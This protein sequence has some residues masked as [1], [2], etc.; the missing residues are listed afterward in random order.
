MCQ[1]WFYHQNCHQRHENSMVPLALLWGGN[2][3]DFDAWVT[4]C[5]IVTTLQRLEWVHY[6][7][8][9]IRRENQ[10]FSI[11]MNSS[12]NIEE[13][14]VKMIGIWSCVRQFFWRIVGV[15]IQRLD[16][17]VKSLIPIMQNL[18]LQSI[19][20]PSLRHDFHLAT[21]CITCVE[22]HRM[23]TVWAWNKN[24]CMKTIASSLNPSNLP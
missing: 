9:T 15:L 8:N 1:E 21:S 10:N 18:V 17:F 7:P 13:Q 11:N 4:R 6:E 2:F 3:C 5:V 20:F 12:A 22:L 16:C 14:S 19:D 24:Y 23:K